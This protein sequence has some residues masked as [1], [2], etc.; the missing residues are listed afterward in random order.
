G[1]K[2]A[3]AASAAPGINGGRQA[4]V[5][6]HPT[7]ASGILKATTEAPRTRAGFDSQ[8]VPCRIGFV[9]ELRGCRSRH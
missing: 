8:V 2:L 9:H 7:E 5:L 1:G 6:A 4:D 3:G